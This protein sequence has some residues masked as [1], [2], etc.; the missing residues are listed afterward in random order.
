MTENDR[1]PITHLDGTRIFQNPQDRRNEDAVARVLEAKWSCELHHFGALA[2]IDWYAV[3]LG[4]LT[5]VLELKS[6]DANAGLYAW[7]NLRKWLSLALA[8]NGLGV[9]A[10]FVA[11]FTDALFWIPLDAIDASQI[12]IAGCVRAVKTEADIEP[13]IKVPL[14]EMRRL[15]GV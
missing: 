1:S 12:V 3:R 4:R 8:Q 9:P 15:T 7:L 10:I 6:R 11:K 2:P 13:I 5:G 14:K